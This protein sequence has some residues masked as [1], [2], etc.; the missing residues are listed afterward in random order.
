MLM[1]SYRHMVQGGAQN[2]YNTISFQFQQQKKK[3]VKRG[4]MGRIFATSNLV[5]RYGFQIDQAN[6]EKES[7]KSLTLLR[8]YTGT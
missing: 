5:V 3:L 7:T 8:R 2:H 6:T 4:E 1:F